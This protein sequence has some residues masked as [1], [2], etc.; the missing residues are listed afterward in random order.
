MVSLYFS[1]LRIIALTMIFALCHSQTHLI[2]TQAKVGG[3]LSHYENEDP[4]LTSA[5]LPKICYP[6]CRKSRPSVVIAVQSPSGYYR[7]FPHSPN[8][9]LLLHWYSELVLTLMPKINPPKRHP[10]LPP[11]TLKVTA[12]MLSLC[13]VVSSSRIPRTHCH[14]PRQ[15]VP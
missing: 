12:T 15:I 7:L 5:P 6:H 1:H 3:A 11:S 10:S 9:T 4:Y 14:L 8:D 13:A 2:Q